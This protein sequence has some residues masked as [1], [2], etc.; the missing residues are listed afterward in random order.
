[1]KYISF[2]ILLITLTIISVP[3]SAATPDI[4]AIRTITPDSIPAGRSFDVTVEI[5]VFRGNFLFGTPMNSLIC[6]T[7]SS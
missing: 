6:I 1:M 3:I 5:V 7:H 4:T 2:I